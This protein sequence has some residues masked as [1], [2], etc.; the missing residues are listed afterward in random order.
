MANWIVGDLFR[1]LKAHDVEI[2]DLPAGP[3]DLAELVAL[4]EKGQIT[5]RNGKAVLEEMVAT[6]RPPGEIVRERGLGKITD[7]EVLAALVD[8][9]LAHHPA[10]VTAYRDGKE[11]LL[12]WFV[13]QVMRLTRGKADP[14]VTLALLRERLG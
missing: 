11:T 4:V 6:G 7:E 2:G 3:D 14:Q 10:E 9:I 1:L 5:A 12:Q 13:G 8:E